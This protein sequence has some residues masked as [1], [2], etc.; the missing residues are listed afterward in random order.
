MKLKFSILGLLTVC[1]LCCQNVMS[2]T[3]AIVSDN[4]DWI[5]YIKD[6]KQ[7]LPGFFSPQ[8]SPTAP[9]PISRGIA[10]WEASQCLLISL[11]LKDTLKNPHI[12]NYYIELLKIATQYLDVGIVY[13][14][15]DSLETDRFI[16]RLLELGVTESALERIHIVESLNTSFWVRDFGPLFGL[17]P[18]GSLIAIDNSY[19]PLIPE[20]DSWSR[21]PMDIDSPDLLGDLKGFEE[22]KLK[23]QQS[24]IV[25]LYVVKFIR[26]NLQVACELVRPPLYLQGGDYF[27]DGQ[28]RFFI[29]ED[30][31]LANGGNLPVIQDIFRDYF[32]ADE[33]FVMNSFPGVSA[34]HLDMLMKLVSPNR[35]L[36]SEPPPVTRDN[37]QFS[38][39]LANEVSGIQLRNEEYIRRSLPEMEILKVPMLPLTEEDLETVLAKTRAQIFANVCQEI[40]INYLDHFY[41]KRNNPAKQVNIEAVHDYLAEVFKKPIDFNKHADLELLARRYLNSDLATLL[42][43]DNGSKTVYRSYLNSLYIL[44]SEGKSAWLIPRYAARGNESSEDIAAIEKQVERVFLTAYPQADFHWVNS[45]VMANSL[46]AIHCTT[47]KVPSAKIQNNASKNLKQRP[48]Q[49]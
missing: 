8:N 35:M 48:R 19:R 2:N 23:N 10:E 27:T 26:Q 47:L 1:L 37:N 36:L 42:E 45:D 4:S 40:G 41:L 13:G 44:N 18:S 11:N 49:S 15:S 38:R 3:Q 29:S 43:T 28:N 9:V 17:N 24:E 20:S 34:K 33:L 16:K 46:G 39:R 6:L 5:E 14:G 22:F 25:P 30:T 21:A 31:V 32:G 12:L 7:D